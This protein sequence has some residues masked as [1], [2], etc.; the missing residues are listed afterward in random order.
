[1]LGFV[2]GNQWYEKYSLCTSSDGQ[3]LDLVTDIV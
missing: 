3:N 1:M 2:S